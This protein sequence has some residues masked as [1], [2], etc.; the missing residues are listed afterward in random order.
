MILK[1]LASISENHGRG[2]SRPQ[3]ERGDGEQSVTRNRPPPQLRRE[4]AR[5]SKSL[6]GLVWAID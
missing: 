2:N 3:R 1:V 4:R 6:I 5:E